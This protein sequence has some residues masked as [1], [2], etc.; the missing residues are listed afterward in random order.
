MTIFVADTIILQLKHGHKMLGSAT[1][2]VITF[3]KFRFLISVK[4]TPFLNNEC[5]YIL[6]KKINIMNFFN[7][8]FHLKFVYIL[9]I[10]MPI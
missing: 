7:I 6:I 5:N 3:L 2:I 10:Y 8:F 1:K 4:Y 9:K